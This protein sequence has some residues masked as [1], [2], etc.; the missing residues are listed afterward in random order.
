M[1]SFDIRLQKW[2]VEYSD[3]YFTQQPGTIRMLL[4]LMKQEAVQLAWECLHNY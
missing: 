2:C 3:N 1:K 4:N